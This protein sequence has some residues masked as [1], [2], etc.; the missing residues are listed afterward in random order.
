M[1]DA[2][3]RSLADVGSNSGRH[4]TDLDLHHKCWRT[5][6][7]VRVLLLEEGLAPPEQLRRRASTDS[8]TPG[9]S[10]A[11]TACALKS[12]DHRRRYSTRAPAKGPFTASTNCNLPVAGIGVE[13]VVDMK[14]RRQTS[15][16]HLAHNGVCAKPRG[17]L[18]A[19][20]HYI[21]FLNKAVD[22]L[23]WG[24]QWCGLLFGCL[25]NVISN[26]YP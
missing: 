25:P 3:Q 1:Q 14:L 19:Y 7:D 26:I 2:T 16:G 22:R 20:G 21:L 17:P 15:L 9:S 5:R 8:I 11:A 23:F 18:A 4:L 12:S 10:A 13:L 24:Q 6:R